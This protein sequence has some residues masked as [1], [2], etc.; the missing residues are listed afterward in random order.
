MKA[1]LLMHPLGH[2]GSFPEAGRGGDEEEFVTK[3]KALPKALIEMRPGD[4]IRS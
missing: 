1:G 3:L 4:E 2:Q